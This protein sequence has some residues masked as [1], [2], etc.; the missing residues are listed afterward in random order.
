[1]HKIIDMDQDKFNKLPQ[2]AKNEINR[3]N[4]NLTSA[5]KKLEEYQSQKETNSYL[6]DLLDKIPLPNN[7]IVL[8]E[9]GENNLNKV[10]VSNLRENVQITC[11]SSIGKRMVIAPIA[12]NSFYIQFI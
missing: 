6:V 12:S 2:W 1:M 8:F 9:T 5:K 11:D 3:L 10:E 7:S 4:A